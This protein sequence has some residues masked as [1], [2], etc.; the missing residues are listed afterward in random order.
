MLVKVILLVFQRLVDKTL[1]MTNLLYKNHKIFFLLL[2]TAYQKKQKFFIY[3][4]R[5]QEL[6]RILNKL[7]EKSLI[8]SY[9]S[10][11][12]FSMQIFLRYDAAKFT[13]N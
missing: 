6:L 12:I 8:G 11:T 1:K 7:Q 10:I 2:K 4:S 3:P 5:N 9:T 13:S